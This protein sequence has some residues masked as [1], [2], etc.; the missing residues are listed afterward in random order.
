M[1]HGN[2]T[3]INEI[4]RLNKTD[5]LKIFNIYVYIILKFDDLKMN[6]NI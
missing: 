5:F 6:S 3:I 1:K 4:S 2:T